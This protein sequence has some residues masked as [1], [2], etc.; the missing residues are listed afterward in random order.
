MSD[1]TRKSAAELAAHLVAGDVSSVEVTQAHL[2]RIS[3]VD[4]DV[5]AFLHVSADEALATARDIDA[6]RAAG[7]DLHP[8]AGVPIAVKD[9]VVTKGL[10]TTA[11]SKILEGWIPPYD[12]TLVEKIKAAGLPILGKTNM[13]E[14]AMGSSTEHSAYGNTRNPWD[15]DRIPGGSG[16]G[17]AAA[18]AA[19]EAPLAI[20]TDTGGSIRQP[21]AVTGTVG[22]KPTYGGV[23]RYGLI[24][25]ASSL[26]QAGPVTRTVLDSA[27]LHE[28][29]GGHDPRDSTSLDEPVPTLVDAARQGALGDLTG[30]RVGVVKELSGEGYQAGVSARFEE[31]LEL[32]KAAGA[33]VVEVSCPHFVNALAAY[34]LIMP[35]EASSN[36]AKFDGMRFGLRVEP[37]EGPVTAERVMSATRGAGFGDE[38]KRRVILGT[39][40]LS[41]GYYDA[42]YGSAQKVRTLIQ[43]DFAAA[44][45]KADVLVSPTSPTTAFKFGEKLD[46]PLAMYLNDVATIPANLAGV[47]GISLPNGLSDDGL[48]VGFQILAPARA[49]ERLYRVG[50]AL[51]AALENAWGGPLLDQAPELETR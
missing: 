44:F 11:G 2:D 45:E 36:L 48:P 50:A 8:L 46:D 41:A 3:A 42:Y 22:V 24:A 38:V 6:R 40:A 35:A 16:G 17:S 14:F 4:T 30:V 37:T 18:V 32:L 23:S 15:L 9:V 25:M 19:F 10:P 28:L 13:D 26:D 27:L 51:E 34:Y 29:I 49:D 43:R 1:L 33:E 5:H 7:E 31:S 20:G 39:Y 12:A 21:G 47:P